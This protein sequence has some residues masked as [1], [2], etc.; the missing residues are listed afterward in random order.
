MINRKIKMISKEEYAKR[1]IVF[2]GN[3]DKPYKVIVV[4]DSSVGKGELLAKFATNL[5]EGKYLQTL[6]VNFL[7][8][9]I[10][11][12]EFKVTIDL[13][14]WDLAPQFYTLHRLYCDNTNGILLVF[15]L[16]RSS[17]F[18]NINDWYSSVISYGLIGIPIILI[19]NNAH[20]K[21]QRT[22]TLT[23]AK[24]LAE[25][26]NVHYYETSSLTGHNV[27]EVFEKIAELIYRAQVLN[28]LA[29]YQKIII[30]PYQGE[31]IEIPEVAHKRSS[32]DSVVDPTWLRL[33]HRMGTCPPIFEKKKKISTKRLT[34]LRCGSTKIRI[35][36]LIFF[37]RCRCL[38]C[39][40]SF[41]IKY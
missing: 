33:L 16:T 10:E 41:F 29:R 18:C 13:V 2:E 24:H 19:G 8:E 37:N 26:L 4:G 40:Y 3:S 25:K 39:S 22:I 1:E 17:T 5:Y 20:L 38:Q 11:L 7:K 30:K 28:A 9:S 23:M 31:F 35:V 34:C 6:G 36:D 15:D 14:F 32:L 21:K 12:K 27:K